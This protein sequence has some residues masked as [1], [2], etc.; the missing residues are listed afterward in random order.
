MSLPVYPFR[1]LLLA[2]LVPSLLLLGGYLSIPYAGSWPPTLRDLLPYALLSLVLVG[3][4]LSW[5]FNRS[6]VFLLLLWIGLCEA[7][8][9]APLDEWSRSFDREVL[10]ILLLLVLPLNAALL[11][12]FRER[13]I[14]TIYGFGW[15]VFFAS[16]LVAFGWLVNAFPEQLTRSLTWVLVPALGD[17]L[18][19]RA[20]QPVILAFL[21]GAL[22]LGLKLL[23]NPSPIEGGSLIA[24][25][26]MELS[27]LRP[28]DPTARVIFALV[29]ALI[30]VIA[31]VQDSHDK[32]YRDE[33]TGLPG[34]RALKEATASLGRRYAIAMLDVDHFKAFNDTYGHDTGDQVLKMVAAQLQRDSGPGRVFRFGGEEFT[35]VFPRKSLATVLP[36]LERVCRGVAD[37]RLLLRGKGRPR[38]KTSRRPVGAKRGEGRQARGVSVTISIGVAERSGRHRT[39]HEVMGAADQALYRAKRKGRNRVSR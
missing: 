10:R 14:L 35:I 16:Q 18:P 25:M 15:L 39:P 26:A 36:I 11:S 37:Y 4:L 34:R 24:L 13:S 28:G 7:A 12:L 8:V 22:V 19:A 31:V 17:K 30:L 6:R 33:L 21:A 29:A 32:A 20:P 23:R 3:I 27:L 1:K 5:R 9:Q 38:R 2:T